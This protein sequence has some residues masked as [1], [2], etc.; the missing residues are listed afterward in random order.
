MKL[1]ETIHR[2]LRDVEMLDR[3]CALAQCPEENWLISGHCEGQVHCRVF[4][5]GGLCCR[6]KAGAAPCG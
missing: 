1:Y 6:G 5:R 4:R 3:R 2:N